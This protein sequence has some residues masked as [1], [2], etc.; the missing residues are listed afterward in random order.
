MS[1]A[2]TLLSLGAWQTP[3]RWTQ[4]NWCWSASH[5]RA[6]NALLPDQV[7]L[8]GRNE[9]GHRSNTAGDAKGNSRRGSSSVATLGAGR[10]GVLPASITIAP[11]SRGAPVRQK[12]H[13]AAEVAPVGTRSA[14]WLD[15]DDH[16]S[17]LQARF[18]CLQIPGYTPLTRVP[19]AQKAEAT[20]RLPELPLQLRLGVLLARGSVVL[21]V[22]K[23]ARH[24]GGDQ[25]C[26]ISV[27]SVDCTAHQVVGALRE[28]RKHFSGSPFCMA[29]TDGV[30]PPGVKD[31]CGLCVHLRASRGPLGGTDVARWRES[32]ALRLSGARARRRG[33]QSCQGRHQRRDC[34]AMDAAIWMGA[35]QRGG[36][37]QR[38]Y[39]GGLSLPR[40]ATDYW[41]AQVTAFPLLRSVPWSRKPAATSLFGRCTI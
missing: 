38:G 25:I 29:L 11:S 19:V 37:R 40:G 41:T 2:V 9:G 6:T 12:V 16:A 14:P 32:S 7:A 36:G 28:T 3:P 27:D 18:G 34:R 21:S 24:H 23:R 31:S 8:S 26:G 4:G 22:H 1:T 39:S 13:G 5:P 20:S 10:S 33:G 15:P 30:P 35:G 17:A